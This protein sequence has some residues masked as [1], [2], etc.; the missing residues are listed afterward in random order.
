MSEPIEMN[1]TQFIK[2]MSRG[3]GMT[4]NDIALN[5]DRARTTVQSI[6]NNGSMT[7]TSFVNIMQAMDEPLIIQVKGGNTYKIKM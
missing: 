3:K 4:M 1:L 7:M 6:V 2:M 5:M